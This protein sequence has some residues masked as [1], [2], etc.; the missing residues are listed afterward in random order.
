[1]AAPV[2]RFEFT[3]RLLSLTPDRPQQQRWGRRP[4]VLGPEN[5]PLIE[6]LSAWTAGE[7][8]PEW[9][10]LVVIG[11][12]GLGKSHVVE[13][14]VHWA[15]QTWGRDKVLCQSAREFA[16][17]FGTS[18]AR[19]QVD[20]FRRKFEGLKV[21]AV[22]DLDEIGTAA[23]SQ[24]EMAHRLD[25][26][27]A[28]GVQV[29]AGWSN[30]SPTSDAALVE[31]LRSRWLAGLSVVI[32]PPTAAT[33]LEMAREFAQEL[34]VPLPTSAA[35]ILAEHLPGG[36]RELLGAIARLELTARS[37]GRPIASDDARRL[38]GDW[39]GTP[40]IPLKLIAS[41]TAKAYNLKLTEL[42]GQSRRKLLVEARG[43][44][45]HLAR[46]LT[47]NSLKKIGAYFGDRDHS[48]VLHACQ[49]TELRL[50]EQPELLGQ[51]EQIRQR[52]ARPLANASRGEPV[53]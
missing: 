35:E 30:P 12:S 46:E 50:K 23:A 11:P 22:D 16:S 7:V 29:I 21:W 19:D 13:G 42:R 47:S 28:E 32:A 52:L 4:L 39:P 6:A 41:E 33:R 10:P 37:A 15:Q 53:A 5:A 43:L 26:L 24:I 38:I 51:C 27:L 34:G 31:R 9:N 18:S 20:R 40:E 3:G 8:P 49:Q 14:L 17:D 25:E 48:T 44:A 36:G 1:M 2:R 45:M